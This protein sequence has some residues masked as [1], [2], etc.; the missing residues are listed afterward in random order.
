[1]ALKNP[2][3]LTI[4]I[5]AYN[6]EHH[7]KSCLKAIA[8]QSTKPDEVIVVDNNSTD[9]TAKIAKS[10]AFVKLVKEPTQGRPFARDRGFNNAKS[11][12]F[13]RIDADTILPP[14]WVRDVLEFY[15]LPANRDISLTGGCYFYNARLG[16]LLGWLQGQVAFRVNRL[17]LGHYILFGSNMAIP[18]Q[19]WHKVSPKVCH[20][21]DIHEDLDLAI[22]LH[23][24]GYSI[25]YRE[26]LKVGVKMRRVFES[27]NELWQNMI[28]WPNTLRKHGL[29]TWI[30]GWA[31]ACTVYVLSLAHFL[32][33]K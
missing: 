24:A 23:K 9:K 14:D 25:S 30:L 3:T 12:I 8:S 20:D 1:M 17:L 11:N 10:F 29:W 15:S 28:W 33:K 31:G 6:E 18:S 27:R 13:G 7:L 16:H 2:L 26:N 19:I 4:V 5:P 21:L 32:F 22:H